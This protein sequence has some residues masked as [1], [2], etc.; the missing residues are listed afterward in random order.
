[1]NTVTSSILHTTLQ[2]GAGLLGGAVID[3]V[4]PAAGAMQAKTNT[5]RLQV[6]AEIV[7]QLI[8]NGLV[9]VGMFQV[10][11]R[12]GETGAGDPTG[13]MAYSFALWESQPNMKKKIDLLAGEIRTAVSAEAE[14]LSGE[15]MPSGGK[16]PKD[17]RMGTKD[18]KGDTVPS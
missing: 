16:Q 2:A 1:M 7:A 12:M 9:T 18:G 11:R 14:Y 6:G 4:F 15:F 17:T 5:Q 13:G 8:V 3:G 10:L